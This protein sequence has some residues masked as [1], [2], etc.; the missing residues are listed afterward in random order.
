MEEQIKKLLDQAGIDAGEDAVRALGRYARLLRDSPRKSV[1]SW[2]SDDAGLDLHFN[3]S[4]R[5]LPPGLPASFI[6]L[7]SGAGVPG[8][9]YALLWPESRAVLLDS[10]EGRC[11]FLVCAVK[12]LGLEHRVR[13]VAGRAEERGRESGFREAFDR[14]TARA[15]APF[16]IFL[17]LASPFA[18]PSGCVHALRGDRDRR[19][20]DGN[21]EILERFRLEKVWEK[22]YSTKRS[23]GMRWSVLYRKTAPSPAEYPRSLAKM[24][25]K[26]IQG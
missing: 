9:V 13:V 4:F 6:D 1:A 20:F 22:S 2:D 15:L 16:P 3:D 5:N 18:A 14:V 17:E 10:R 26:P 19:D 21:L 25:K 24:R 12:E 8:I 23:A 7:G 11:R